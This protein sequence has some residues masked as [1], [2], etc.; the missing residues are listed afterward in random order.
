MAARGTESKAK[1]T[2]KI[3]E[4]FEGSF[5]YEKEIR[6]PIVENGEVL[7]IKCVLTCAKTNVENGGDTAIP[8][9]KIGAAVD[10]GNLSPAT[11]TF[12]NEPSAEEKK[13]VEDL[14]SA[15]GLS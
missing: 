5:P 2:E 10:N 11:P 1:I 12:I 4:I 14:L 6:I 13:A 15:L 9:T 8:G 3:L 7:Q